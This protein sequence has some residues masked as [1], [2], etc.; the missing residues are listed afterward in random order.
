MQNDS[1]LWAAV[2]TAIAVA[3][4][5]LVAAVA[6]VVIS[7]RT[8]GNE[9]EKQRIEHELEWLERR[10]VPAMKFLSRVIAVTHNT[11]LASAHYLDVEPNRGVTSVAPP[12]PAPPTIPPAP[13]NVLTGGMA[14]LS[15]DDKNAQDRRQNIRKQIEE[16]VAG[17]NE[18]NNAWCVSVLLD[19]EDSGLRGLITSTMAYWNITDSTEN[20]AH[21]LANLL[22]SLSE[23]TNEFHQAGLAIRA[24]TS[25]EV[26]IK[27][28]KA[29]REANRGRLK[30]LATLLGVIWHTQTTL[31]SDF[32]EIKQLGVK[33]EDLVWAFETASTVASAGTG[34]EVA[35]AKIDEL[36]Q[37]CI[38]RRLLRSK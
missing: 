21:Y 23:L 32:E 17:Q 6:S 13:P 2:I 1:T 38:K 25:L 24:G 12:R 20:F 16:V 11:F 27:E 29:R 35:M 28:R 9:R 26:L 31:A 3:V 14:A 34:D 37:E 18:D 33:N 7:W 4:S 36:R 5:S 8:L 22:S 19:P 15:Q 30:V 10:F